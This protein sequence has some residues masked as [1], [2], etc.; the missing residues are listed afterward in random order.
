MCPCRE[1]DP[2][3][4]ATQGKRAFNKFQPIKGLGFRM[5]YI[6]LRFARGFL[7]GY[8]A[9]LYWYYQGFLRVIKTV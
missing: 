9:V 5:R 4:L 2:K 8:D 1:P 6:S 3:P 7:E